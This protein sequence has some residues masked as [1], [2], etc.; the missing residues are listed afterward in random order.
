MR[1]LLI[2]GLILEK[3]LLTGIRCTVVEEKPAIDRV[4]ILDEANH[5]FASVGHA[6]VVIAA[7]DV[8]SLEKGVH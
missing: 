1:H 4:A 8:V 7:F 3:V 2:D 5:G 6:S